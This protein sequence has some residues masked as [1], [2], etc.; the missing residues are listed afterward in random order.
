MWISSDIAGV[1]PSKASTSLLLCGRRRLS[2]RLDTVCDQ[3]DLILSVTDGPIP[4]GSANHIDQF[5]EGALVPALS[6]LGNLSVSVEAHDV[7]LRSI[8]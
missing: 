6:D 3:L 4:S 7:E 2:C 5:E 8:N 1:F